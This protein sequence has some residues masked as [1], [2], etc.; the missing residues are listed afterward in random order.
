VGTFLSNLRWIIH[1]KRLKAS[2][3]LVDTEGF[4][5]KVKVHTVPK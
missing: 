3:A 1:T 5:L 4:V 2:S